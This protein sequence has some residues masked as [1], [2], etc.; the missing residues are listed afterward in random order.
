MS[1]NSCVSALNI[2][3]TAIPQRTIIVGVAFLNLL[4]NRMMKEGMSANTKALMMTPPPAITSIPR[5]N[6]IAAPK[7]APEDIPMV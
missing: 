5:I 2:Y 6:A 1:M 4:R 3:I 7:L